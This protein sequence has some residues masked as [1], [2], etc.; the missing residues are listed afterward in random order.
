MDAPCSEWEQQKEEEEEE[1]EVINNVELH[2][3]TEMCVSVK[4]D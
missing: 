4:L 3:Y 2:S 1:E